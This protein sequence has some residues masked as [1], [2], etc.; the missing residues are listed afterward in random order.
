M[1]IKEIEATDTYRIR[2]QVLRNGLDLPVKFDGDLDKCSFHLGS[3]SQ[4]KLIGIASFM[5]NAKDIFSGKQYQLRG[6]A[7]L[8]EARGLGFGKALIFKAIEILKEKDASILWC[9]ARKI[10][11]PF[12]QNL[13]FKIYGEPFDIPEIGIHYLLKKEIDS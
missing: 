11:L 8:P 6:M 4:D 9:N 1:I 10:A 5:K 2:K 12:Y 13:G 7:T 3:F